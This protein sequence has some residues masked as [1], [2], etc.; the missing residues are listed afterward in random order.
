MAGRSQAVRNP[1]EFRLPDEEIFVN[2]VGNLVTLTPVSKLKETFA[3]SL[4]VFTDD[5]IPRVHV[6]AEM[7]REMQKLFERGI[8]EYIRFHSVLEKVNK[9]TVVD[10]GAFKDNYEE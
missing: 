7:N 8:G 10:L 6:P 4:R 2:R 9:S 5:F 1:R 3:Q